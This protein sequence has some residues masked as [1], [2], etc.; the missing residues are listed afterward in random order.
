MKFFKKTQYVSP[1]VE[2]IMKDQ[3]RSGWAIVLIAFLS[4]IL[5]YLILTH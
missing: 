2:K 4:T 1:E 3:W 5:G